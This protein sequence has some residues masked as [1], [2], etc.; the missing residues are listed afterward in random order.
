ML[1][2]IALLL[3]LTASV[4]WAQGKD[5][6]QQDGGE[7]QDAAAE[8]MTDDD[9]AAS[10][11]M[12]RKMEQFLNE[13]KFDEA[14]ALGEQAVRSIAI[15][16]LRG[17]MK[18]LT[19]R[20][21]ERRYI[22]TGR[23]RQELVRFIDDVVEGLKPEQLSTT[24]P[25]LYV[26]AYQ[27]LG[28]PDKAR[29]L[30]RRMLDTLG[31]EE[32]PADARKEAAGRD[33]DAQ[34]VVLLTRAELHQLKRIGQPPPALGVK[35]LSGREIKL[36]DYKGQVLLIDF[37]ATWCLPCRAEVANLV[38]LYKKQHQAGLEVVGLSLDQSVPDVKA[39]L[40]KQGI[41][42][43]VAFLGSWAHDVRKRYEVRGIPSRFLVDR[44][45]RLRHYGLKGQM[46]NRA[47]ERLLAEKAEAK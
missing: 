6:G 3:C 29:A 2:T 36:E 45:G 39:F 12:L 20:A 35:D 27:L 26:R 15:P 13:R 23:K 41:A 37:W 24:V 4:L 19:F 22:E 46:V 47:V 43:P 44:N 9:A 21:L 10:V 28:L 18:L 5:M 33:L 7:A 32:S 17:R 34:R 1:R 30:A 16:E 14:V 38:Q 31:A 11:A 42:W 40:R 25:L 8:K